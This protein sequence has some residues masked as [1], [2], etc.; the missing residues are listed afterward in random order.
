VVDGLRAT[1]VVLG[2]DSMRSL[3]HSLDGVFPVKQRQR[4]VAERLEIPIEHQRGIGGK[5]HRNFCVAVAW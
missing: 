4:E 5:H 3:H 2:D 1:L